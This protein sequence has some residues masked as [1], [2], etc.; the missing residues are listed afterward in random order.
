[1]NG[2]EGGGVQKEEEEGEKR[3]GKQRC[4]VHSREKGWMK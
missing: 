3:I 4:I 2:G 1:M